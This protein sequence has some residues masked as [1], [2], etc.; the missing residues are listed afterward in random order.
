MAGLAV[1]ARLHKVP[2]AISPQ[3][4]SGG[5]LV[6]SGD[7][8][9]GVRVP[10]GGVSEPTRVRFRKP[11]TDPPESPMSALFDV[12][13]PAVDI[14]PT[15]PIAT[16]DVV[17][18]LDPAV[19]PSVATGPDG[20]PQRN[21]AG[22]GVQVFNETLGT[23]VT[24][25]S[26]V[27]NGTELVAHA[28]HF[29]I[30][31]AIWT[32]VGEL[33][34]D[35]GR[36]VKVVIDTTVKAV[37]VLWRTGLSLITTFLNGLA[38]RIDESKYRCDPVNDEYSV[39]VTDD[40]RQG[41]LRACVVKQD[42]G[43]D[44]L[45]IRN[46]LAVPMRFSASGVAGV[47]PN[48]V[49]GD[50][51]L[52]SVAR[53]L[54]GLM[55]N[56]VAASGLDV[57]GFD[58]VGAPPRQF[59]VK[60][61]LSWES[62]V[63]DLTMALITVLLPAGKAVTVEYRAVLIK[64]QERLALEVGKGAVRLSYQRIV[65]TVELV[66]RVEMKA[67]P[68]VVNRAMAVVQAVDC[69]LNIGRKLI[70]HDWHDLPGQFV[71]AAR[72]C[73]IDAVVTKYKVGE[74]GDIV[75]LLK[76]IAQEG[77]QLPAIGQ[78]A[79]IGVLNYF[80]GT[81]VARVAFDVS[82]ADPLLPSSQRLVQMG[83]CKAACRITGQVDFDHPTWGPSRLLTTTSLNEID[84][85][86]NIVVLDATGRMRW[87]HWGGDWFELAPAQ[88]A[89]DKTGH[90]FLNYNPGRYNGVIVLRPSPQGFDNFESLP[91]ENDYQSRFYSASLQ[92]E[93]GDGTYEIDSAINDCD[94]NC[95]EGTINHKIYRW[96]GR[97]YATV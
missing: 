30:F 31:R 28:P 38:G 83:A 26:S 76:N 53:N 14:V 22:A 79:A 93:N 58:V 54:I 97:T 57:A 78:L 44:K 47:T 50:L 27:Q 72:T 77:K 34:V 6:W 80:T 21:V 88:P 20:K 65:E 35:A 49:T 81:N 29:S 48:L 51:D 82:K 60:G 92:D 59:T 2:E 87:H 11:A 63:V 23:W 75:E 9:V 89:R 85:E 10:P 7:G 95:A 40:T 12:L 69:A 46:G 64:V 86:A 15:H 24:I 39:R 8:A 19:V 55:T 36:A 16:A 13:V 52:V 67:S 42:N 5:G 37:D 70:V 56:D 32:K 84:R 43:V 71:D 25:P 4:N 62:A 1:V 66:A 45:L 96:N 90:I 73:L 68:T 41:Q 3:L 18:K 33:V 74:G 61:E 91:P 17:F 94:P